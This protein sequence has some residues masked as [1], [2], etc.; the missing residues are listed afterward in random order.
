MSSSSLRQVIK[1]ITGQDVHRCRECQLCELQ[2]G[3]DMDVP[4]FTIIRMIMFD[5][6]E[7]LT[8]RTVW[9]ERVLA[10]SAHA[11]K[12]GLNLPSI[13]QALRDEARQRDHQ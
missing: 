11:C 13:L 2:P 6:E 5:D 1:N 3:A 9:S 12:R 4:L 8:C 10:E 7:V